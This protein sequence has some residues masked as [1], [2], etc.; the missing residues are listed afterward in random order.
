MTEFQEQELI[1]KRDV[2]RIEFQGRRPHMEDASCFI[3]SFL[4]RENSWFAAI[5]DGHGGREAAD[6]AAEKLPLLFGQNYNHSKNPALAFKESFR[7]VDE[8]IKTNTSAG[9]TAVCA[10]YDGERLH[11]ANAGDARAV[12]VKDGKA[13]QLTRDHRASDP[14]EQERIRQQG[15]VIIRG[16]VWQPG[17]GGLQ[18]ARTLGDRNFSQFVTWE[19]DIRQDIKDKGKLILACDGLFEGLENK[20]LAKIVESHKGSNQQLAQKLRDE[21]YQKGS[22]DNISVIAIDI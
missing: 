2:G 13:I 10:F 11:V 4:G 14:Q 7:Q 17:I 1:V 15:G 20:Y 16:Y 18:V 3:S 21:A 9:T 22:R 5:F 8:Q 12:L 19:P 6:L